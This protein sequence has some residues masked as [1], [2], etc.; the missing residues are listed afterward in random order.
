VILGY[1]DLSLRPHHLGTL[2]NAHAQRVSLSQ[3]NLARA[4]CY[5][6]VLSS[7]AGVSERT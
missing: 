1:P 5:P 7:W 4:V 3:D 6:V 2:Y